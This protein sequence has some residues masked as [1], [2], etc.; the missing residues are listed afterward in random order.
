MRRAG[1]T[2]KR[3]ALYKKVAVSERP[4]SGQSLKDV[5]VMI[6]SSFSRAFSVHERLL[7]EKQLKHGRV[8]STR[9]GAAPTS[10]RTRSTIIH[11]NITRLISCTN[12]INGKSE[13]I[14]KTCFFV[15]K[16]HN[17]TYKQLPLK[18]PLTQFS[19]CYSN[20]FLDVSIKLL[21]IKL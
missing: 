10:G 1:K 4:K 13:R 5:D 12:H 2:R 14:Y 17:D 6:F 20:D 8:I 21:R 3:K 11:I 9:R 16:E 15:L 19:R 18:K 7:S